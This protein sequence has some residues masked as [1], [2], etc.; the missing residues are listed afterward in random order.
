LF[1]GHLKR[2]ISALSENL[3]KCEE[4]FGKVEPSKETEIPLG[5]KPE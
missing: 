3:K 1:L 2:I 5:F 4:N